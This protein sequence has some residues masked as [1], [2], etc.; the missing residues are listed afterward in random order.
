MCVCICMY[1]CKWRHSVLRNWLR[2]RGNMGS[3]KSLGQ[4]S[5]LEVRM[6]F[7]C[8]NLEAEFLLLW[9]T[10]FFPK[11]FKWSAG[12]HLCYE[13]LVTLFTDNYRWNAHLQ[14]TFTATLR[15]VSG[16]RTGH[17]GLTKWVHEPSF[18]GWFPGRSFTTQMDLSSGTSEIKCRARTPSLKCL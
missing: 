18:A 3:P 9:K 7:L 15:P 11:A 14:N 16:Q 4:T 13:G 5:K 12:T 2:Q 8:S 17:H 10:C 6:G 1:V